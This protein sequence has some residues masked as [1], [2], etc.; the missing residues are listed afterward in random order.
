ME[1]SVQG[2]TQKESFLA[3]GTIVG[4]NR[5]LGICLA[6]FVG[7]YGVGLLWSIH[8]YLFTPVHGNP[9]LAD[10]RPSGLPLRAALGSFVSRCSVVSKTESPKGQGKEQEEQNLCSILSAM[11][12]FLLAMFSIV[13]ELFEWLF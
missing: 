10:P 4:G 1:R 5:V 7:C 6:K 8:S 9:F 2:T 11:K 12:I 13:F 3:A